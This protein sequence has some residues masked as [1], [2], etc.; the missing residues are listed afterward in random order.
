MFKE[1][2]QCVSS[3]TDLL[4]QT[5]D[6]LT[7]LSDTVRLCTKLVALRC[8]P[9]NS[10]AWKHLSDLHTLLTVEIHGVYCPLDGNNLK[11]APFLNVTT[12]SFDLKIATG[13]ITLLQHSEFPSLKKFD[14]YGT[15]SSSEVEHL[16]GALS[17]CNTH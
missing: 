6:D 15:M 2:T 11:F 13:L 3:P 4:P 9:L 14:F 7:L 12:L 16:F 5:A 17:Q 10:S 8:P 1:I